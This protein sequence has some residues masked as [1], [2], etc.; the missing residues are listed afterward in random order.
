MNLIMPRI[1]VAV[2]IKPENGERLKGFSYH[3]REGDKAKIELLASGTKNDFN[4]DHIFDEEASQEDIFNTC[5]VPIIKNVLD[6]QN[7]TLF[8]YGQVK[9]LLSY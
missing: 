2:R 8:A 6:G 1:K 5:C 4:F 9:L 3:I 7:G